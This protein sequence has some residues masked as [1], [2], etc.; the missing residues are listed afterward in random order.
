MARS[1]PAGKTSDKPSADRHVVL[2]SFLLTTTRDE[3]APSRA[4]LG[5]YLRAGRSS[6]ATRQI[7]VAMT[8]HRRRF[9]PPW[10]CRG[11]TAPVSPCAAVLNGSFT[12]SFQRDERSAPAGSAMGHPIRICFAPEIEK[13]AALSDC[14]ANCFESN[15][16][17]PRLCHRLSVSNLRALFGI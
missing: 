14:H 13:R 17:V 1:W 2:V 7:T 5:D 4:D 10:N 8:D 15:R 16:L 6:L 9:P 11:P 12:E 3:G